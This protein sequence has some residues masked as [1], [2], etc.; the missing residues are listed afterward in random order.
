L[1]DLADAHD[2]PTAWLIV[3]LAAHH[4]LTA[5]PI[6]LLRLDHVDLP[7]RR[8]RLGDQ[9]RLI[10]EFTLAALR[11]YLAYRQAR[12]PHTSNPYLLA[13]QQTAHHLGP[14]G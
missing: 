9:A 10:D 4:A 8:L 12:W 2:S 1:D 3:V 7:G 14:A 11:D 5:N 13:N 6:R